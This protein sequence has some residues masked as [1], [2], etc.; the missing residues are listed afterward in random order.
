[1][2]DAIF[3]H[4]GEDRYLPTEHCIGPWDRSALHGGPPSAL[5]AGHLEGTIAGAG[6]GVDFVP[7]RLTVELLR[8]MPV[9]PLTVSGSVRR[10]GRRICLADATLS[11][12]DGT[13][14]LAATL[15]GIRRKPFDHGAPVEPPVP[16]GPDTGTG[17]ATETLTGPPAFH[18]TGVEHR[19]VR[20]TTFEGPGPATDWIRLR[21]PL[22]AGREP[23][24]LERTV[25]AAD[26][27]NGVSR[28]FDMD[29]M[30]FLN[31]DLAVHLY[32]LPAGEWVCLD[33]VT[34]LGDDGVGLAESLLF[35]ERGPI[36]RATQLLLVEPR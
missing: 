14:V 5:L 20:G 10:P 32:R 6:L 22:V 33:S 2:A 4:L 18:R 11:T 36:G 31:P 29:S 28:L 8:P 35:D 27:G 1:M 16:P 26:F 12:E 3:E 7:A 24:P 9:E 15:E 23:T 34:R 25:V 17:L 30:L 21:L 13:V 19:L